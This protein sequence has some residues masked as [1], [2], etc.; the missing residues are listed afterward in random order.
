MRVTN[1]RPL[2]LQIITNKRLRAI[3]RE[4]AGIE[5]ASLDNSTDSATSGCENQQASRAAL[6]QQLSDSSCLNLASIDADLREFVL[7]WGDIALNVKQSILILALNS[8][9][10]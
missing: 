3:K 2:F 5:P 8:G 7:A 6:A 9:S 1:P 4:A 10:K